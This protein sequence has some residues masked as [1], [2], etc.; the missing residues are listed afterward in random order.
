MKYGCL[1]LFFFIWCFIN[2]IV[3]TTAYNILRVKIKGFKDK[4]D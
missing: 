4:K 3:F 2:S 1:Y